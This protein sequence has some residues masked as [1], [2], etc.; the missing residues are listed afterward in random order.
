M[1]KCP[2]CKE[3]DLLLDDEQLPPTYFCSNPDCDYE[4]VSLHYKEEFDF[5]SSDTDQYDSYDD[6]YEEENY[7]DGYDD[8]DSFPPFYGKEA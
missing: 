8:Y 7:E 1:N 4:K 6:D 5:L 3:G 2:V